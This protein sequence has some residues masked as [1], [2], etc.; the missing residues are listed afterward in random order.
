MSGAPAVPGDF[1]I[2]V[3]DT[4]DS[5]NDE[6]RRR[7]DAG[8]V[9]PL[10]VRAASQT[11]GRG[12]RGRSWLSEP[13]NLFMT[14][15]LTLNCT[16]IQAANLSFV[17]ALAVAEAIDHFVDQTQVALKWP[18]DVL[19]NGHKTSGILLESWTSEAGLQIAIGI[20]VNVVTMPENIDQKI[21]C[22]AAH[23]MPHVSSCDAEHVAN[24]VVAHFH[25]WL[26]QW[27]LQGFEPIREAW[28]DRATGL[29]QEITA[30][31]PHETLQGV[32]R[33][34]SHDGALDLELP[35]STRRQV[36]AGDIFF[37]AAT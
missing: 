2:I 19:I 5:T 21:T 16:P 32:F 30:K 33:G 20:G 17:A 35:D 11:N 36:T 34:L 14:A 23:R 18:N 7:A 24:L 22:L 29:G 9:G 31:L 6:V 37:P 25:K 10:W 13:G 15:L 8:A 4:V 27:H 28:L 26:A 3:L 12:R 1:E